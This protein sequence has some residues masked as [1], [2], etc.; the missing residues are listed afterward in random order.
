[1]SNEPTQPLTEHPRP[2]NR[3]PD[4]RRVAGGS[5]PRIARAERANAPDY[6]VGRD[7]RRRGTMSP[8]VAPPSTDYLAGRFKKIEADITALATTQNQYV[9][10]HNGTQRLA[11]GWQQ[12]DGTY[13]LVTFDAS[14]NRR[15]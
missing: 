4:D 1:M 7:V 13:A 14:G 11:L 5:L 3:G 2:R 6:A 8:A 15:A 12:I 10:D 9:L